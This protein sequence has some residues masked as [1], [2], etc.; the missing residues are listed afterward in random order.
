MIHGSKN[1]N[2]LKKKQRYFVSQEKE[3]SFCFQTQEPPRLNSQLSVRVAKDNAPLLP[4]IRAVCSLGCSMG[5]SC[6]RA[7]RAALLLT[8]KLWYGWPT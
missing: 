5:G 2:K 3:T 4:S 6:I 8:D 1:K 7:G